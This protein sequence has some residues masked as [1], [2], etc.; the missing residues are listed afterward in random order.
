MDA[1][2]AGEDWPWLAPAA[3]RAHTVPVRRTTACTK[4]HLPCTPKA[5]SQMRLAPA[6]AL[7]RAKQRALHAGC[8]GQLDQLHI[9]GQG[10]AGQG[11]V[12]I[13]GH[14]SGIA[15]L[16]D[17]G[18]WVVGGGGGGG[19][20]TACDWWGGGP[21]GGLGWLPALQHAGAGRS[22]RRTNHAFATGTYARPT[23]HAQRHRPHGILQV[24]Q[25]AQPPPGPV[26]LR[27]KQ[28]GAP[29]CR[30]A[31]LPIAHECPFPATLSTAIRRLTCMPF[32]SRTIMP[33]CSPS[34]AYSLG[35]LA[36]RSGLG[37][38]A[39]GAQQVWHPGL[40]VNPGQVLGCVLVS[41]QLAIGLGLALGLPHASQMQQRSTG[42]PIGS[43]PQHVPTLTV[44]PS[45]GPAPPAALCHGPAAVQAP[46]HCN[47]QGPPLLP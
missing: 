27:S 17:H 12:G 19:P 10:L 39:P 36:M 37:S 26:C 46:G 33:G 47:A 45:H 16:R 23:A 5:A 30:Q 13:D 22:A 38:P 8:L 29:R 41:A 31:S 2:L 25:S 40:I 43:W 7:T 11:R 34:G 21:V 18:L 28:G 9:K 6:P 4:G 1:A 14:L 42:S 44:A 15:H 3:G 24:G 20:G 32:C 35:T